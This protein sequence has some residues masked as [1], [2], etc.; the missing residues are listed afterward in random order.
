MKEG[1]A[2]FL[3]E[4]M[5][6]SPLTMAILGTPDKGVK[7]TKVDTNHV[8]G[9]VPNNRATLLPDGRVVV[10]DGVRAIVRT[11]ASPTI[12]SVL[13]ILKNAEG[14]HPDGA[15]SIQIGTHHAKP[16]YLPPGKETPVKGTGMSFKWKPGEVPKT[17]G[18]K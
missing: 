1:L 4:I 5:V 12:I 14:N 8:H 17:R 13:D 2:Q 7:V 9:A 11:T 10:G 18:E 6:K 16:T 15:A 3:A